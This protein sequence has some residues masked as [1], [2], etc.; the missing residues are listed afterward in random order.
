MSE[1][2]KL[3]Y[4]QNY[5]FCQ[6]KPK[7]LQ[8]LSQI[9]GAS[10][11]QTQSG[12]QVVAFPA[13]RAAF[14]IAE[15]I[16]SPVSVSKE[17]LE[18]RD[19]MMSYDEKELRWIQNKLEESGKFKR[20]LLPHQLAACLFT[21]PK[22]GIINASEQ[23]LGKTSYGWAMAA[24]WGCKRVLI[25]CPKSLMRTWESEWE[26]IWSGPRPFGITV[27]DEGDK[28]A[29]ANRLKYKRN[30][31]PEFPCAVIVNYECI[32]D[33]HDKNTKQV[34]SEGLL[35]GILEYTPDC[36]ILDESFRCKS[37]EANATKAITKIADQASHVLLLT[38]TPV[39]NNGAADLYSQLRMLGEAIVPANYWSFVARYSQME[40]KNIG[41]RTVTKPVGLADPVGLMQ[42]LDPLWYRATKETCLELPPKQYHVVKLKLHPDV[43]KWYDA[44]EKDGEC[45]LGNYLSLSG[46]RV[47]NIRLHQLCGG[48][49]PQYN[50]EIGADTETLKESGINDPKVLATATYRMVP[51]PCPKI[52]WLREFAKD[53]L[54]DTPSA[55]AIVWVRYNTERARIGG[56]LEKTL[57][58]GR[59][60][61]VWGD[62]SNAEVER[63]KESFNSRDEDGVQVIVAQ[64][65]KM[66]AGHNLQAADHMI[67]F[68]NDWSFVKRT[69]SEDRSHRLGREGAVEYWDLLIEDSIDSDVKE[70]LEKHQDFNDRIA[71]HTV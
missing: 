25:V 42:M 4:S 48:F 39:G 11:T 22:R 31:S 58:R 61:E 13:N 43:Q 49:L 9:P 27:M 46:N 36:L 50:P 56:E 52:E 67:Y 59:V 65:A 47:V 23:G 63:I 15:A 71:R 12:E 19:Q 40:Q 69:Q 8:V 32:P 21:L 55:R 10:Y 64:V 6:G 70:A 34:R 53:Q 20:K 57:G 26:A 5:I 68:S 41:T 3:A 28:Q 14:L 24:L 66:Y 38:G 44:I 33:T 1:A 29:K 35:K 51:L 45:V 60:A 7:L 62:T 37:S 54:A 17:Y 30:V 2:Y 18:A 16:A